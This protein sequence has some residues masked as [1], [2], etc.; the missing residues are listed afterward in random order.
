MLVKVLPEK[1]KNEDVMLSELKIINEFD[2][3]VSTRWIIRLNDIE[4]PGLVE[5]VL[6]IILRAL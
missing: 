6:H 2:D 4:P 5:S 1:L 3:T